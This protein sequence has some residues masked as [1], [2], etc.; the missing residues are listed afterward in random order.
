MSLPFAV[1]GGP[2]ADRC[3]V[4]GGADRRGRWRSAATLGVDHL[5]LRNRRSLRPAMADARTSTSR[6]RKPIADDVEANMLAIPRKQRA[7]VR[8]GIKNGLVERDRRRR[9]PLLRACMRTTCI[10][11]AR[12][13]SR[14]R[15]F[16]RLREVFGD[17]CEVLV[18]VDARGAP[19]SAAC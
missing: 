13:R 12:R 3:G 16:A 4:G 1:Y 9:R 5:E 15:Y 19:Q 18:V 14:K 11:T 10:G 2:A 17:A 7:M 8:K 6:F